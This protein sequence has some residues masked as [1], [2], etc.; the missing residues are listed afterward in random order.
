[1]TERSHA[2]SNEVDI[3]IVGAGPAGLAAAL[4]AARA[5]RSTV[6]FE[7]GMIG[8]QIA[9]TGTVENYPGFPEGV[10]GL[11]LALAMHQQAERFGAET[12]YEGVTS[13]RRDPPYFVLTTESGDTLARTVIVTA[14]AEANKLGVPGEAELTGKGVSFCATCDAAFFKDVPIAVVGGGD[15][16]IDEAL[17]STRFAS[18]VYV[19]HRRDELRAEKILQERAL[20][21]PRIEFIWNTVVERINGNGAVTS[22]TLRN[23]LSDERRDLEV[24]AV[25]IFIGQNANSSLLRGL[26]PVDARGEVEVNAWME[27]AVPGLFV[28]GDLRSGAA[29]QLVTA[30]GDGATAAIR[31]D[32]YISEHFDQDR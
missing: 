10:N 28:A 11:D 25:F 19:V 12:R 27:T 17:F 9:T 14:G 7:R 8:G 5:R 6:L 13:L 2:A 30:A 3:A 15:S 29:K 1:V 31:A 32:H 26:V 23:V 22:A 21:N 4:Y 20:A 18:K 24:S 16:A